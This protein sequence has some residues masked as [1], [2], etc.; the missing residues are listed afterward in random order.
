[1]AD[2]DMAETRRNEKLKRLRESCRMTQGE[3]AEELGRREGGG[4]IPGDYISKL[5]RGVITWPS[6]PRR[7]EVLRQIFGV[8][9]DSE[10]GFYN[11]RVADGAALPPAAIS[12]E[13]PAT[14]EADVAR[15]AA[16]GALGL[17][18]LLTVPEPRPRAIWAGDVD[19]LEA[20]VDTID[21]Q[22]HIRGG[23]YGR[24]AISAQ[25][26]LGM[27]TLK[28][29]DFATP[30]VRRQWQVA[31]SRA[32]RLA[33][34]SSF[35]AGHHDFAFRHFAVAAQLAT[36]AGDDAQR[37]NVVVGMIRQALYRNRVRDAATYGELLE[38]TG[39]VSAT[40][41][42]MMCVVR[43]RVYAAQGRAND[44]LRAIEEAHVWHAQRRPEEDPPPLWFYD[45]AQLLGD[46]G[47]AIAA[48]AMTYEKFAGEAEQRLSQAIASHADSDVRGRMLSTGTLLRLRLRWK[49]DDAVIQIAAAVNDLA[50]VRSARTH[51]DLRALGDEL[52][53]LPDVRGAVLLGEEISS[54]DEL[55]P[56]ARE[57]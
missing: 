29:A 40:T 4:T 32:A 10:L 39:R 45:E 46:S 5:E 22:D 6:T 13:I 50:S 43:A 21:H 38:L 33:G 42:A 48:L 53:Q 56:P 49:P 25:V 23:S 30:A 2:E 15:R 37:A 35:D 1:M 12:A 34:W 9:D 52:V 16:L 20:F 54:R 36:E 28:D 41:R 31:L 3:L 27:E 24:A 55:L 44:A 18:G 26:R 8:R 17:D 19:D 57:S 14:Q 7:R 51:N 47:H 11:A